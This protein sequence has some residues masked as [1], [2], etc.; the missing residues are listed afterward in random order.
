MDSDLTTE[1]KMVQTLA[2]DFSEHE[3]DPIAL[4][5]EKDGKV[6]PAI[7]KKLADANLLEMTVS[8]EYDGAGADHVSKMLVSEE[9][10]KSG[11]GVFWF[12]SGSAATIEKVG[13]PEQKKKYLSSLCKGKTV[14][15]LMFTEESTGSD[16]AMIKTTGL[17][18]GDGFIING[19]KLFVTNGAYDGPG[20]VFAKDK[21]ERLS[22]FIVDKNCK[23]Y[24][25]SKRWELMGF[26][27]WEVNEVAF[28]AVKVPKTSLFG[29][30]GRAFGLLLQHIAVERLP[31]SACMVGLAQASLD[32]AAMYSKQRFRR[33]GP[34][35]NTESIQFILADMAAMIEAG[36]WLVYRGA[37]MLDKG[38]NIMIDSAKA[39]LFCTDMAIKA[40]E[41]GLQVHGCYGYVKEMKVER[42]Y[43]CAKAGKVIVGSSEVQR[44]IVASS[45]IR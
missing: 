8:H 12:T 29:Q 41:M 16:A 30:E 1:Q 4:Q 22:A 34:I 3:I 24:S 36:R 2:K 25:V 33:D 38:A 28:D 5:I 44:A 42:L 18:D 37:S 32:E 21:D 27:G 35:A 31:W 7:I 14:S 17:P 39:K 40:T 45:I 9:L 19:T 10:G 20:I 11:T 26:A 15:A 43:R 23:G 13:T 6:P